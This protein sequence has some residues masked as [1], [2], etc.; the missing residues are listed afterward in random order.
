L[1]Q[2]LLQTKSCG[3]VNKYDEVFTAT[4]L[5]PIKNRWE[6]GEMVKETTKSLIINKLKVPEDKLKDVKTGEG[7]IIEIEGKKV[8]SI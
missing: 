1:Q 3:K 7:K 8:R 5:N 6:F 4:R 2:K